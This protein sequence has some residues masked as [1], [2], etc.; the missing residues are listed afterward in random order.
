MTAAS[1]SVR[2][3][4]FRSLRKVVGSAQEALQQV[5]QLHGITVCVGGFGLG[6]NPETLLHALAQ[7]PHA[8][9][10]T[11]ASLT[12]GVDGFGLGRLLEAR[13]IKRL[14]SSYVGE[15][16][17]L[18]QSYFSGQLEVE[19]TPQGTL[20]QRMHAAG[21]GIPAFFTPTGAGTIYA[22]GGIPI[23]YKTDGSGQVEIASEPR[24][25]QQ[26]DGIDYVMERALRADVSLVKAYKADTRGNLVFRGTSRNSNPDA[27][28][29]GKICLAE[30]EIIVEAGELDP[31]EVHLPGIY[32]HYLIQSTENEKRIERLK[33]QETSSNSNN[34]SGKDS[35]IGGS[36]ARIMRR[37]A[38]EFQTGMYVNLGIGMPTMASNYIPPGIKIELQ[39]E[40]GLLGIGPY[41]A[42]AALADPDY[43]N[44]GKETITG[45]PGASVF[46]SSDSFNMIRGGHVDLTILGGLQC[47]ASGDLAN[48]IVPGQLV[49]GMGGAM[50]LVGAPGSRVVVTMDH[51]AKNGTPKILQECTL[52]L[53]G[54]NVVDRIITEL[55]VLDCDKKGGTG[56]TLVEIA[57]GVTV[58]QVRAATA[59]T[60]KVAEPLRLM[61]EDR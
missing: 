38:R 11:V 15:N 17:F 2:R 30:A 48:W 39:A 28:M 13:K 27:A 60:F 37:A 40:N 46:S 34:S 43:I 12:G 25:T 54:H 52:P 10:L 6:G 44:A 19:L 55:C 32:V 21:A 14:M 42:S 36:R 20:A 51:T 9:D 8:G 3:R 57:P 53:T 61:E 56:L 41:P 16:K 29:A 33:C 18:E 49:K 1:S 7:H 47:S 22:K 4:L 50:D 5:P 45:L 26:F 59:A 31:N 58:D 35:G 23:K 24:I